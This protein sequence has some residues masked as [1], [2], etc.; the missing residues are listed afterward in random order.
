MSYFENEEHFLNYIRKAVREAGRE[1]ELLPTSFYI[2]YIYRTGKADSFTWTIRSKGVQYLEE[3]L[4]WRWLSQTHAPY[5]SNNFSHQLTDAFVNMLEDLA[6]MP[7]VYSFWSAEN[8]LLY[9]GR[10]KNLG[11]RMGSSFNRFH[12]YDRP[13]YVRH[14]ATQSAAD[15]V[16]LEAYFITTRNPPLNGLDNYR[17][18]LT[19]TVEPIPDWSEPVRCNWVLHDPSEER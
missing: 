9:V 16:V 10:S 1:V 17:D 6:G 4:I 12:S 14:I 15:A 11:E 5:R 18:G 2:E 7:G 3:P 13:V 8:V 19:L